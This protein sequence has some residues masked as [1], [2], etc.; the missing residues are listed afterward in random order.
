MGDRE[1]S[2]RLKYHQLDRPSL[3]AWLHLC[4][5]LL[6]N[7]AKKAIS[8]DNAKP[9]TLIALGVEWIDAELGSQKPAALL[10]AEASSVSTD[11]QTDSKE[12]CVLSLVVAKPLRHQ[13]IARALL[14][15]AVQQ[16]Q[17]EG[18]TGVR[19]PIPLQSKHSTAL[20]KLTP[21]SQ[22]WSTTPGE[23]IVNLSIGEPV[24]TLLQRL[25]K[26][27]AHQARYASWEMKPFPEQ[28]TSSL[29]QRISLAEASQGAGPLQTDRQNDQWAP[30]AHYSR[31]LTDQ[32]EIIGWLITH[33]VSPNCL[34]YARFW[35]NPGWE[36]TSAPL[37]MLADVIR[38]AHF[39]QQTAAIPKGC[40]ISH[41]S[42]QL[43]HHFVVKQFKPVCDSWMQLE[44]R[45]LMII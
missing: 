23:V 39:N 17:N 27:V 22:G 8:S 40:F 25:E 30:A 41:P 9:S 35:V 29:R 33:F 5:P 2:Q 37:A 38:S 21:P 7:Y 12:L 13:G 18:L 24:V 42:N 10:L 3:E 36:K 16:A 4:S 6:R 19:F 14:A 1:T 45:V 34:R 26:V 31:L 15:H 11:T 43:L 44:H 28:Q 32:N 20:Q